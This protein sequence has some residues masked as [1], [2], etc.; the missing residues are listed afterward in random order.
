MYDAVSRAYLVNFKLD[1]KLVE[2]RTV[3]DLPALQ[4]R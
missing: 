3:S 4:R 1:G 2:S